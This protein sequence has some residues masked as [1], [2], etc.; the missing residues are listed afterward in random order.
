MPCISTD[1]K[2]CIFI[3]SYINFWPESS[4][5]CPIEFIP[6]ENTTFVSVTI[7]VCAA[8]HATALTFWCIS[9]FKSTGRGYQSCW[10]FKIPH[11]PYW[12]DP[13]VNASELP[14]IADQCK[15][16]QSRADT[17]TPCKSSTDVSL[18]SCFFFS[19]PMPQH[20]IS[21]VPIMT[22]DGLPLKT[23]SFSIRLFDFVH[24]VDH[25]TC[26]VFVELA[27][28]FKCHIWFV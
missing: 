23:C 4:P 22:T 28:S 20:P 14:E 17:S 13:Q 12:L 9:D 6:H 10:L 26:F 5:H 15:T 2:D 8:P 27:S 18:S 25:W 7:N 21:L 16:P 24:F 3:G 1:N 11:W 19:T